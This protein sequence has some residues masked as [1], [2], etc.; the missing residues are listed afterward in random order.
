MSHLLTVLSVTV[1][2]SFCINSLSLACEEEEK[3]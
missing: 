2:V 3:S 1:P